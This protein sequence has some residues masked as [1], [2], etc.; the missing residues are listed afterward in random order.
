M[1]SSIPPYAELASNLQAVARM[2][3]ALAACVDFVHASLM[4][5]WVLALPLLFLHRWPR[6]TRAYAAYAIVFVTLN[7]ASRRLLGECFLTTL[8]RACWQEAARH[9]SHVPVSQ[10]WFTVRLAEAVFRLTPSHR[11]VKLVSE[12]LIFA[13]AIG[14]LVSTRSSQDRAARG[15]TGSRPLDGHGDRREEKAPPAAQPVPYATRPR[16]TTTARVPRRPNVA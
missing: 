8:A 2:W 14:V 16:R 5:A 7:L 11:G 13:T 4:A 12:A 9:G 1:G 15:Q 6:V 3:S 10:E